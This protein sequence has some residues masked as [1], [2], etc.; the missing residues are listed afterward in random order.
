MLNPVTYFYKHSIQSDAT[1]PVA[2][3]N[4]SKPQLL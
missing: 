3:G 1:L 4:A 2:V